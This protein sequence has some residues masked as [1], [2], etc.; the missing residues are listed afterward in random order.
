M[1]HTFIYTSNLIYLVIAGIY[2]YK[3]LQLCCLI[4]FTAFIFS[5]IYHYHTTSLTLLID[6]VFALI[7]II[8]NFIITSFKLDMH[9]HKSSNTYLTPFN[10]FNFCGVIL[11]FSSLYIKKIQDKNYNVY[12]SLWHLV[13]GFGAIL[14]IL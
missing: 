10:I 3:Q 9:Y 13:S 14:L 2:E 8:N 1:G 7:A 11:C 4:Y 5:N 12:H 6:Q